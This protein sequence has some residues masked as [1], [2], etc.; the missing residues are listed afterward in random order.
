MIISALPVAGFTVAMAIS[1]LL[2][3]MC[4][5]HEYSQ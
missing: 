5:A 2:V 4:V 1:H 3:E